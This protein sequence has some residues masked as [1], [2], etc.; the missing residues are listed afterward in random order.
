MRLREPERHELPALSD[1]CLRSKAHWGYS[2]AMVEAFRSELTIRSDD[3][4]EDAF[5]IAEDSRGI[6]GIVQ[7]S[8]EGREAI[9]EKLF[10]EPARMGTGVGRLLYD[11]ACDTARRRGALRLVIDSDPDAAAFYARMGASSRGESPSGSIPGRMLPRL[12]QDLR[13]KLAG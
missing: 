8:V 2:A 7:V 6:A 9:L 3:L 10:I 11:W 1:L 13:G 5:I 4:E 12:V